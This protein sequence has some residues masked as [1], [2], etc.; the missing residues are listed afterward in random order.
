MSFTFKPGG[1]TVSTFQK[2]WRPNTG[3]FTSFVDQI[4]SQNVAVARFRE[5]LE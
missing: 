1:I 2:I 3:N 4:K 5:D